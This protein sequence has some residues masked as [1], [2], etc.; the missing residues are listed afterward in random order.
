MF[1]VIINEKLENKYVKLFISPFKYA[2]NQ[3][4]L[5]IFLFKRIMNK[6]INKYPFH[7]VLQENI[8]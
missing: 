3:C 6:M 4:L 5:I 8:Y 2:M 1:L 7:N